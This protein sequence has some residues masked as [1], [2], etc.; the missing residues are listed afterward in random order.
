MSE[1]S[2]FKD[3]RK[4]TFIAGWIPYLVERTLGF[5]GGYYALAYI[6]EKAFP[7]PIWPFIAVSILNF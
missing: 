5:F 6:I 1:E 7:D 3:V 4:R 2:Y